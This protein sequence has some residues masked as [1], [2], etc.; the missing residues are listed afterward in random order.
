MI[1]RT[2]IHRLGG[3]MAAVIRET[4][5]AFQATD[6]SRRHREVLDAA[7]TR[8][9][10]I[11]R[12]KDG[13][14]FSVE[15]TAAVSHREHLI[16]WLLDAVRVGRALQRPAAE[17]SPWDFGDLGW[18][19]DLPAAHQEEF[20]EGFLSLLLKDASADYTSPIEQY[21]GDW[22]A[23]AR[24]WADPLLRASLTEDLPAPIRE[25]EL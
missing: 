6:L 15:P 19:A 21:L 22:Q 8:G 1:M 25:V 20:L 7:R 23:T 14:T 17:R 9:A 12:D 16:D 4:D 18:L 5:A 24:T 13:V 10:A 2:I 3:C 11:I